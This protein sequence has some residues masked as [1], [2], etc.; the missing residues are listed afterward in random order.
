MSLFIIFMI[1]FGYVSDDFEFTVITEYETFSVRGVFLGFE[2]DDYFNPV[3]RD[4]DGAVRSFLSTDCLMDYFLSDHVGESIILNIEDAD[5]YVHHLGDTTRIERVT[6]IS[7]DG[8]TYTHWKDSLDAAGELELL[9]YFYSPYH[10][11]YNQE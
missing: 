4:E 2:I 8:L 7:I 11:Q 5:L 9:Q 3:V 6:G 10:C 1:L